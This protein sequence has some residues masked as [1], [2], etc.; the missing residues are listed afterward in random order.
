MG[1]RLYSVSVVECL[2]SPRLNLMSTVRTT[3]MITAL[4]VVNPSRFS[5]FHVCARGHTQAK[6]SLWKSQN[7]A[8]VF[9]LTSHMG[10]PIK[11]GLLG[12]CAL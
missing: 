4:H 7:T 2:P 12:T 9:S 1:A 5:L 8:G 10:P 6:V 3:T 11:L